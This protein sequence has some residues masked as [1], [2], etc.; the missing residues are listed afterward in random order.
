LS[1]AVN[2]PFQRLHYLAKAQ[3]AEGNLND[4]E[5]TLRRLLVLAPENGAMRMLLGQ[6]LIDQRRFGD[7]GRELRGAIETVPGA[8]H[9]L[10][11]AQR[12]TEAD[13]PLL[14]RMRSKAEQAG[15]ETD[16]KVAI[17]F[18]L[19]KAFDD[20]GDYEEAMRQYDAANAMVATSAHFN[21]TAITRKYEGIIERYDVET[22]GRAAQPYARPA[23]PGDDLPIAI[24][25]MP[26]SGTTLTEQIL[27]S[28]PAVAAAGELVFWK[29]RSH[30]LPAG[31]NGLPDPRALS[32]TVDDYL[33]VLRG[34]GPT[35]RRV[36]DKAPLN[37]EALGLI[38]LA[39]PEAR[40]IHC[41]RDPTDTGLSIYF[42]LF[43]A[44]LGFAFDRGDIVFMYRQYERLMAHWRRV[45]P[46]DRF[47]ELDY[48]KLVA[49]REAET[50]RLLDFVGLD[51][52]DACLAHERNTRVVRTASV[53]QARQPIYTTSVERWRRYEPWIGELRALLP[54]ASASPAT[55]RPTE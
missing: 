38:R 26:R 8:F 15:S 29:L 3:I 42:T 33:A 30:D 19:G 23:R 12:M 47:L 54:S 9:K 31:A 49:D 17:R 34:V 16:A 7:A 41:R 2:D 35:A 32:K 45:L 44:S 11:G 22:L 55:A 24:V 5:A 52:D 40:I 37:F 46:P 14:E 6:V 20:L 13:R 10:A 4:A 1:R 48:E 43:S 21:R 27:S 28:H 50:R 18:G 39:F 51:W 53:W 25:G 36:T